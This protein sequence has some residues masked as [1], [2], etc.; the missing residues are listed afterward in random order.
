MRLAE[1]LLRVPDAE[2]AIALTA[3][4]LG[5]A[6]FDAAA[7]TR[8]LAQL[9]HSAIALSKKF[10]PD[11]EQPT[12]PDGAPR[13]A[14][15]GGGDA[16][17]GAAARPPVRAR[18]DHRGSDGR[19][20]IGAQEAGSLALQLRHAGRRRAHRCRRRCAT[21]TATPMRS[22]P[23]LQAQAGR[24]APEHNDGI[25]IK[26]SA[27]HPRYEDAQR[28]RVL[29]R[30]GAARVAAVRAGGAMP[31]QPHDRRRRESTGSSCRSTCSRR[32]PRAWRPSARSGAASAWRCR[33]TRRGRWSW[34]STSSRSR[35]AIGCAS[36][37]G[38]SRAPTGTRRSSARR[39]WACRTTRC[40]RTSTTPTSS[41]LACARALLAAP[42][43]IYPQF[44]THN[45]GTIAAILQMARGRRAVRAPAPARHG[46]RHLP[47]GDAGHRRAG[48]RLR[49]GRPPQGPAGLPGAPPAGKRREF[50]LRQPARR[51]P[52]ADRRAAGLAAVAGAARLAAAAQGSAGA[53]PQQRG[54]RPDGGKHARAAAGGLRAD[55]RAARCPNSIPPTLRRRIARSAAAFR[56]WR[57]QPIGLRTALL[58]RAADAMQHALPRL[59]A[60]LVKEAFK[61][62]GDAVAEVRE[63]IDFLRYY[64]DEAERVMLPQPLPGPTGESNEL[65]LTGRGAVGLHQPVE[66]PARDLHRPGGGGAGHRQHGAG[67]AGRADA[68]HRARG[69]RAAAC[70]RRA[71]RRAAA[72][73]RPRRN[74]GRGAG[75]SAGRGGRGVHRLDAGGEADPPRARC[76]GRP[77]RAA[78]R[79]NRRHQRD[80]GR[81]ERAARAGGRRRGAERVPLG[82]PALLGAAPAGAA[83]GDR[84]RR[85]RDDPRR[86]Q[87][88]RGGRPGRARDRRRPG[89]RRRGGRQHPA[90]PAAP[91]FRSKKPCSARLHLRSR[92]QI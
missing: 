44:A 66:F 43:A 75:G 29:R 16:A 5:R 8:T 28:E 18:P 42:D 1:A 86:R 31:N 49:A 22:S 83:P 90:P 17:R 6:D 79:R 23:S 92:P 2:T 52:C 7:A 55:G 80:A 81:F 20:A 68:G 33:P 62:W 36:C 3:D 73:A 61:T 89:D 47:R 69:G 67:Q 45:A 76:Q 11:G 71:A 9:S 15:G 56:D 82:R 27:L 26:L 85:D 24:R 78:D 46:R 54:P 58:R 77:D 72:A 41:Y 37:A 30:A 51:R 57:R 53:A 70:R 21:S 65:R 10:L 13:R 40:S 74:G 14:D 19:G 32:W 84:R 38:W 59:C 4:Q 91:G 25:S 35:A 63:A 88:T 87:G 12:R 39:S 48:A 64:A 60:L 34:W 50:L